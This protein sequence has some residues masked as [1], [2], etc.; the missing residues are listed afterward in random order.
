M[1]EPPRIVPDHTASSWCWRWNY[2]GLTVKLEYVT[3]ARKWLRSTAE[4]G[5]GGWSPPQT[6]E[7]LNEP[8][9]QDDAEKMVRDYADEYPP[10]SA[11]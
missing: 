5:S 10:R 2:G 1:S 3:G 7:E 11:S 6:P 9:T 4:K 8:E